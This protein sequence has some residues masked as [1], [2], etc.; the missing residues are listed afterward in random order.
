MKNN[1]IVKQSFCNIKKCS[2]CT[3][4]SIFLLETNNTNL[5]YDCKLF[6]QI[7]CVQFSEQKLQNIITRKHTY[8]LLPIS[9]LKKIL[10]TLLT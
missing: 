8:T 2:L 4:K 10:F 9:Q 5:L 1:G 6:R 7:R 3:A